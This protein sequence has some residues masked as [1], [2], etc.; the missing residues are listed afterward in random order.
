MSFIYLVANKVVYRYEQAKITT[1]VAEAGVHFHLGM[2]Y[3][4]D[5]QRF[6]WVNGDAFTY[7]HW[8]EFEPGGLF[9]S[10]SVIM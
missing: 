10:F 5:T 7:S 3:K 6:E 2:K 9:E 8:A 1:F 4:K